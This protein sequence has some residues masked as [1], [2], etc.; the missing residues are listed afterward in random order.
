MHLLYNLI[1]SRLIRAINHIYQHFCIILLPYGYN[2]FTRNK[3]YSFANIRCVVYFFNRCEYLSMVSDCF[4]QLIILYSSYCKILV[5]HLIEVIQ[6]T[7]FPVGIYTMTFYGEQLVQQEYLFQECFLCNCCCNLRIDNVSFNS[8][9]I[10]FN[11]T[12]Y[13]I[14]CVWFRQGASPNFQHNY[15]LQIVQFT[16]NDTLVCYPYLSWFRICIIVF[17]V[18]LGFN[19]T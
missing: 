9:K 16:L 15:R 7:R 13:L 8:R 14:Y 4:P 2:I 1:E 17:T 6:M 12:T 19:R 10:L 5:H 11:K 18:L 3:N